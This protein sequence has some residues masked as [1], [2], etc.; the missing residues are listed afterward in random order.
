[1]ASNSFPADRSNGDFRRVVERLLAPVASLK[2]TV[3]L[4]ALSV[5]LVFLGTVAQ[6]QKDIWEVVDGY[7]RCWFAYVSFEDCVPPKMWPGRPKLPGGFYFFGGKILL[8]ALAANLL[9]AHGI[10]FKIQAKGSQLALGVCAILL[11]IMTTVLVIQSGS[12]RSGVHAGAMLSW[13]TIWSLFLASLAV[14]WLVT[15]YAAISMSDEKKTSRWIMRGVA[16]VLGLLVG[17][18]FYAGDDAK[19]DP[20]SMRILWQLAKG[21]FAGL[22]LLGGCYLVFKQRAPVVVLHAGLG[23]MMINEL[24]VYTMHEESQ[25]NIAEGQTA[26]YTQDLRKVELAIATPNGNNEAVVT[27]I[28]DAILRESETA[29]SAIK[30]PGLPQELP[31]DIKVVKYFRNSTL[32]QRKGAKP[33]DNLATAGIGVQWEAE[34]VRAGAGADSGGKVDFASAYVKFTDKKSGADLGTYLVSQMQD[35]MPVLPPVQTLQVNDKDYEF[36]IR[37]HRIHKPY[38][39]TLKDIRKND[40]VG[41]D[42]PRDY[43]SYVRIVDSELKVDEEVRVW[44]NNPL[45]FRDE[46]FY[47][48]GYHKDPRSNVEFT[49]LQV[50]SN[51]GWMIPYVGCMIVVVGMFAQFGQT[52]ARFVQRRSEGRDELQ[53]LPKKESKRSTFDTPAKPATSIGEWVLIASVLLLGAAMIGYSIRVPVPKADEFNLYEFGQIPIAFEGRVKPL[54]T[55]ARNT[56]RIV[57][58]TETFLDRTKDEKGKREPAI[59]WFLDVVTNREVT[60]GDKKVVAAEEH[61][62]FKIDNF[63]VQSLL[64]LQP[65]ERYRYAVGE[66]RGKAKEFNDAT[67]K[68]R[69]KSKKAGEVDLAPFERNLLDLDTRVRRFTLMQGAFVPPDFGTLPTQ[70]QFE[71]Q[72]EAAQ[73]QAQGIIQRYQQWTQIIEDM[74]PAR[75]VPSREKDAKEPWQIMAVVEAQADFMRQIGSQELKL[76][77]AYDNLRKIFRAYADNDPKT[78]NLEVARYHASLREQP[79]SEYQVAV[80]NFETFYNN[81]RPFYLCWMLYLLAFV[82]AGLSFLGWTKPLQNAAFWLIVLTFALHTYAI[83][84][85]MYISGRPPVTNLYTTAIFEGWAGVLL[86][87]AL[88]RWYRLGIGNFVAA[89]VGIMTLEIADRLAADGDTFVVLQ[90]V[91]D[92]QFWL[93]THVTCINLGYATTILAGLLGVTQIMRRAPLVPAL[94]SI[95]ALIG[96]M[97]WA[98]PGIDAYQFG[99]GAVVLSVATMIGRGDADLDRKLTRMTYGTLCFAIFFSFWGTVLGGLWADDSWGRFWGWDPKENGALLIV[100][101]NAIALHARWGNLVKDRGLANLVVAGNVV[102]FWSWFVVND[103]GIGL[104]A[105]GSSGATTFTK[106]YVFALLQLLIIALGFFSRENLPAKTQTA[107]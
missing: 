34:D 75:A 101:W 105:Y 58:N 66:F 21:T 29:S 92:T 84:G 72:R 22:V 99:L 28:P 94:A 80:T 107:A 14:T 83:F 3:V 43:S 69:E 20:S 57:S 32:K 64:G 48:S 60:K 17:A 106:F 55:L 103:L 65:R 42:T 68:A 88:E 81:F 27:T 38:E 50:V 102:T 15:V 24:V 49:T 25:M 23:L 95:W 4:L 62:V 96:G 44:M 91:L 12:N 71:T 74:K 97:M 93:A 90:A 100:L 59:K 13:D 53:A 56:L 9:A 11:G 31:F 5:V 85:R 6:W 19:L 87:I 1:M 78:F 82:I 89:V 47:Q 36:S 18:L 39:I 67:E 76:A 86:G 98:V 10:R 61:Q 54:D 8:I 37:F 7:F 77:P 45:R 41:T 73:Q 51:F 40:Y 46:T 52:F 33:E 79:P 30:F 35:I 104:H 63:D 2:L 70:E 16:V 26:N